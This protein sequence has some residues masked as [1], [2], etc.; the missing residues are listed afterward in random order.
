MTDDDFLDLPLERESNGP[1]IGPA[2]IVG[3]PIDPELLQTHCE[4]HRRAAQDYPGA[5]EVM[6]TDAHRDDDGI[7]RWDETAVA[8]G[9]A[10]RQP[11]VSEA[12]RWRTIMG[13][14]RDPTIEEV[15][16]WQANANAS[17]E[18]ALWYTVEARKTKQP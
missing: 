16:Q 13:W 17:A 7:E 11:Q 2:F 9:Q 12:A 3:T 1:E 14:P 5:G 18:A 8:I 6:F 15:E 10:T 4:M